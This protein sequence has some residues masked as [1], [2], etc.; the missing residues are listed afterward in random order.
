[1]IY[2]PE[3]C[4]HNYLCG[5]HMVLGSAFDIVDCRST[6]CKAFE[7]ER[8]ELALRAC[9]DKVLHVARSLLFL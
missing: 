6:E 9:S 2:R 4:C 3:T 1:M 5:C 7:L 8:R